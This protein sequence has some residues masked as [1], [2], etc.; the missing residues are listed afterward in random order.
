MS[1]NNYTFLTNHF[2]SCEIVY[3]EYNDSVEIV[4]P[5]G[6]DNIFVDF[7][8]FDPTPFTI[9]FSFQHRHINDE[10]GVVEYISTIMNESVFAIEFFKGG[11]RRFGGD[12]T[13]QE[14]EDL[15]YEKLE[16]KTGYYGSTK[17]IDCADMFKVRGWSG[18]N[19][20]DAMFVVGESGKVD[21]KKLD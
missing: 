4:N 9:M 20:F 6:K 19:S 3:R 15:S 12:I 7:D 13:A 5:F 2:S 18:K 21:I 14:L 17:L 1:K 11:E 10:K 8:A 16:Q